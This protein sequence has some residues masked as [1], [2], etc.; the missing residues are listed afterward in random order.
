[1]AAH[2]LSKHPQD[3]GQFIFVRKNLNIKL[4]K[5][6]LLQ[7]AKTILDDRIKMAFDAMQAAQASANSESKSSAGDKYETGRAMGQIERDLNAHQYEKLKRERQTLDRIDI[8]LAP[9]RVAVG[10]LVSTSVGKFW[11]A[12]SLGILTIDDQQTMVVSA[13]SP[14]GQVLMGLQAGAEFVFQQKKA[15]ITSID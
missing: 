5:A 1:M 7:E 3:R 2:S 9:N 11:I 12:V 15:T 14:I 6:T 4:L 10:S 13:A 8:C